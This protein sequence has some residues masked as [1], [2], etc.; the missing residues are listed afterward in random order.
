MISEIPY[1]NY[2]KT[3]QKM[4]VNFQATSCFI[5]DLQIHLIFHDKKPK[6]HIII[7]D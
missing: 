2:T 1:K 7:I 4:R 5:I 6:V 3:F